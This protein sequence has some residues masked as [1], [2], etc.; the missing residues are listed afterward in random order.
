MQRDEPVYTA[1]EEKA[2]IQ[3]LLYCIVYNILIGTT[4]TSRTTQQQKSWREIKQI[5]NDLKYS[6][7][8]T[9]YA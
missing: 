8:R 9:A 1:D 2:N 5:K 3:W 6:L 4:H 7:N